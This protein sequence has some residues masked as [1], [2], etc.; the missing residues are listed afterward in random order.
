LTLPVRILL[1]LLQ[2]DRDDRRDRAQALRSM[3]GRKG[4]WVTIDAGR[5]VD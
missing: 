2:A 5:L 3:M 4:T 1:V